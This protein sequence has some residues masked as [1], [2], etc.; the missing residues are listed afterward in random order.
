MK[1]EQQEQKLYNVSITPNDPNGIGL[2]FEAGI[3]LQHYNEDN[4]IIFVLKSPEKKIQSDDLEFTNIGNKESQ[5]ELI[6]EIMDLDAKDGLYEDTSHRGYPRP[7]IIDKFEQDAWDNYEHVEG[8]LY[9]TTFRNAFKLGYKKA[10]E[11]LYTEEEVIKFA[12][13]CRDKAV[14]ETVYGNV[15][16]INNWELR[17]QQ[18]VLTTKELLQEFLKSLKQHKQ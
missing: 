13:W 7:D 14:S 5:K 1:E 15:E 9:S 2:N 6:K 8:N 4:S 12:E 10:Q 11:T 16:K 18:K 3:L 17:G